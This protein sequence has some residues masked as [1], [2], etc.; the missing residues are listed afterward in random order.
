[1]STAMNET[2]PTVTEGHPQMASAIN[3]RVLRVLSGAHAGA[4]P[5]VSGER[6]LIGNLE[7]ECDIVLDVGRTERHACLV[8]TSSDSWTVLAIAGDLWTETEYL[9]P[10]STRDIKPGTVITLGRVAFCVG[11]TRT[12]DWQAI[13]V[14]VHL[15]KPEAHGDTQQVA[16]VPQAANNK[17]KW[18]ALKLAAGIGTGVLSMASA[19][20]FLAEAWSTRQGTPQQ[21]A[22]KLI[23]DQAM[24]EALPFG[25]EIRLD[26]H[27]DQPRRIRAVGYVPTSADVPALQAALKAADT[28]AEMRVVPLDQLSAEVSRRLPDEASANLRY[29]SNGK[30]TT[31]IALEKL[32]ESDKAARMAMQEL[33]ALVSLDFEL[34]ESKDSSNKPVAVNYARSAKQAGDLIVTNLEDALGR[35]NFRVIEV[36]TGANPSVVLEG[37][38]RYFVGGRLSDGSLVQ[39]IDAQ[40]ILLL[41]K[42]GSTQVLPTGAASVIS[43]PGPIDRMGPSRVHSGRKAAYAS[44][45]TPRLNSA[46]ANQRN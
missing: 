3:E 21:A 17:R 19:S 23:S 2:L 42:S 29:L 16:M 24:V 39:T 4:E 38:T 5:L 28:N 40:R 9:A 6:I 20:A 27:P 1:M 13:K 22:Q 32:V 10:Q 46:G 43:Q 37:G 44:V 34:K 31:Q 35:Q 8:R 36:R 15:T 41:N 30:F 33:P 45:N 18:M 14:P 11:E 26:N 25:R 12:T 7:T